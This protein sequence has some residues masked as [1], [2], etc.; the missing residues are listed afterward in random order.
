LSGH[1][2]RSSPRHN[3]EAELAACQLGLVIV[4]AELRRIRAEIALGQAQAVARGGI[5]RRKPMILGPGSYTSVAWSPDGSS[6]AAG[7]RYHYL[8]MWDAAAGRP[9]GFVQPHRGAVTAVA[10]SPDGASLASAGDDHR[11]C[12]VSVASRRKFL[13]FRGHAG[14]VDTLAWSPDG[15]YIVSAGADR[16]AQV[17]VVASGERICRS[18]HAFS[19]RSVAWSPDGRYIVSAGAD[20]MVRVWERATGQEC[21]TFPGHIGAVNTVAWSSRGLLASGDEAGT[22]QVWAPDGGFSW[23]Q[24]KVDDPVLAV[25]WAPDGRLI[26]VCRLGGR[27]EIWDA[28]GTLVEAHGQQGAPANAVAWSPDG[29]RIASAGADATVRIWT[30]VA[31]T[32]QA[33]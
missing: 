29:K 10:Y 3:D 27:V 23:K 11:V 21:Y 22:C 31:S 4:D 24:E 1:A 28:D 8:Q 32:A 25:A 6:L 18:Q 5:I 16:T 20:R 14:P 30:V 12:L 15:R 7:T 13:S 9:S 2:L 17:W 19:V 26:G 33:A